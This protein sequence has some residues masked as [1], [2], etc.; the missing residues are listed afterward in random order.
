MAGTVKRGDLWMYQFKSPDKR[1]P[2][3]ILRT[4]IALLRINLVLKDII[5]AR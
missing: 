3:L 5:I 4:T 1:R 2:V